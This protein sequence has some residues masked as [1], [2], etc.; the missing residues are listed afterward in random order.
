MADLGEDETAD[1]VAYLRSLEPPPTEGCHSDGRC[2]G[3]R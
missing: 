2:E 3:I 1:L